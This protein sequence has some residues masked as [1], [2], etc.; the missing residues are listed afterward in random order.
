MRSIATLAL[1]LATAPAYADAA[2]ERV[3]AIVKEACI[4]PATPLDQLRASERQAAALKW[5]LDTTQSGRKR[6]LVANPEDLKRPE[7]FEVRH[8]RFEEPLVSGEFRIAVVRPEWAGW[9]QNGC[10]VLTQAVSEEHA[11]LSARA[12]LNLQE[13]QT[14]NGFGKSWIL[15]G[16]ALKPHE[17]TRIVSTQR[18]R[19]RSGE[20][21][22]FGVYELQAPADGAMP[23]PA[24]ATRSFEKQ[25][26][27]D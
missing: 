18:Q 20:T 17:V 21:T 9:R 16:D 1:I 6:G 13:P 15:S 8:W 27:K 5:T 10:M 4:D 23:A 14:S 25:I 26:G 2:A 12:A 22:V 24:E 11:V 3:V 7:M 19:L